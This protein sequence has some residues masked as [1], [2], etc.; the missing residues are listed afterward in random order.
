MDF[1]IE[2][3]VWAGALGLWTAYML[4][5]SDTPT[6]LLT[7][8]GYLLD[9][10][11]TI[12]VIPALLKVSFRRKDHFSRRVGVYLVVVGMIVQFT[13]AILWF[14]SKEPALQAINSWHV[15]LLALIVAGWVLAAEIGNYIEDNH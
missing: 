12:V 3:N 7:F 9:I 15:Y 5:A 14:Q 10:F 1:K 2:N 13:I 11:I 4:S 6:N 8:I